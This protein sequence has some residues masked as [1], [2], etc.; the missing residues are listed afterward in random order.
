M[1]HRIREA[2]EP[3]RRFVGEVEVDEIYMGGL[4]R[5]KHESKKLHAFSGTQALGVFAL[6]CN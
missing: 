3:Q 2:F 4:E 1:A 5:N 6:I